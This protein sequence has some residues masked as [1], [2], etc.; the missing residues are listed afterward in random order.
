MKLAGRE[1]PSI[2]ARG[3]SPI[4][5][6]P[7]RG[8]SRI[9]VGV[10]NGQALLYVSNVSNGTVGIYQYNSGK[11]P[12]LAGELTGFDFPGAPCTDN[13]G[14]VFIPDLLLQTVTEY[15]YGSTTPK[16]TLNPGGFPIGC[17]VDPKTNN[18]AVV[19]FVTTAR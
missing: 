19:N 4:V 18:L 3:G 11:N 5:S 13:A 2:T 10:A 16:N 14:N 6:K 1:V 9:D 8:K 15:A 12:T 17:S 7:Y